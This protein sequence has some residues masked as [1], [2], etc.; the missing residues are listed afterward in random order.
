M[1]TVSNTT[2]L[3]YL[4]EIE[5]VDILETL[6]GRIFIPEKVVEELQRPKTP[7]KVKD[8]MKSRPDWLEVQRADLSVFTPQK[9]I[10]DGER[11]AFALA[12]TLKADAVLIDDKNAL[13]EARRLN[14]QTISLFTILERAAARDLIDL[15]QTVDKMRKTTFRLPPEDE[16]Q[17]MLERDKKR[18]KDRARKKKKKQKPKGSHK[19]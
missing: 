2:P 14:L 5:K 10:N 12:L 19:Q 17:A 16:I 8:W 9:K 13:P 1:I 7:Q 4:I 18:K 15:P 11:E 6:F 3:R